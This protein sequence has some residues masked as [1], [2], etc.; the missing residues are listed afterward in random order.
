MNGML[1]RMI[2]IGCDIQD[3]PYLWLTS[4]IVA[5]LHLKAVISKLF[6]WN[7]SQIV[8]ALIK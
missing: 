4:F 1:S 8:T 5:E 3:F 2:N 7:K 6:A